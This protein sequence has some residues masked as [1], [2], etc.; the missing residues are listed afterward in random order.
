MNHLQSFFVNCTSGYELFHVFFKSLVK[1]VHLCLDDDC[2]GIQFEIVSFARINAQ[3]QV[4][5]IFIGSFSSSGNLFQVLKLFLCF[6][7]FNT[8]VVAIKFFA[9][10]LQP[11]ILNLAKTN[12]SAFHLLLI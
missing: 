4:L 11:N 6:S 3:I 5:K 2:K 1:I 12:F 7:A 10:F 8:T 9:V